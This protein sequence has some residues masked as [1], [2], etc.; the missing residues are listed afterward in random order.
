MA[1]NFNEIKDRILST[2]GDVFVE[3]ENKV[4]VRFEASR[5]TSIDNLSK[6]GIG[7][8]IIKNGRVGFASTN[9]ASKIGE[10]FRKAEEVS[11][12]GEELDISFPK[13]P[14]A[15]FSV[16]AY[17]AS[18]DD[19]NEKDMIDLGEEI[20]GAVKEINPSIEVNL[21]LEKSFIRKTVINSSG[22]DLS[23][24]KS[25][26][27]ILVEGV[28]VS[29]DESLLWLFD[30]KYT[31]KY[32]IDFS[33]MIYYLQNLF[34]F[35]LEG[36]SISSGKYPV[37]FAPSALSVLID[38]L[39]V[40]LNGENVYKGISP[41]KDK[42]GEK[43]FSEKFTLADSPHLD[44]G[45]SSQPFDDEGV[46]TNYKE[47]ISN[48]VLNGFINDL[49]TGYLQN[50]PSS[51][52]GFRVYSQLPKPSFS[53]IVIPRGNVSLREMIS[54]IDKG[55]VVYNFLGGGQSNVNAGEFSVNVELGFL[56]E[57]GRVV[58]RVKDT[59]LF[60]NVFELFGNVVEVSKEVKV[61]FD[62]ILPYIMVEGVDVSA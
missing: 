45:I 40:S 53:N 21:T 39:T 4:S 5:L 13:Q 24:S 2:K 10:T 14:T 19:V 15:K 35:S 51:G 56:I 23:F 55:L 30:T 29:R 44:W 52:N 62:K 36:A 11:E 9:D 26:W 16:N 8:R 20:I 37:I 60:G 27:G 38:I 25:V 28:Y 18:L 34:L 41:I 32:D 3:E 61:E 31:C 12:F 54:S 50:Q 42:L 1:I 33:N 57:K 17:D 48:G 59:M 7:V 46:L 47:I 22:L 58:G 43:I 49:R 6:E